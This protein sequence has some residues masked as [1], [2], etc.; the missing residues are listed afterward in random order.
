M[1]GK[2]RFLLKI[3]SESEPYN[4]LHFFSHFINFFI[5]HDFSLLEDIKNTITCP[6]LILHGDID[7]VEVENAKKMHSY[8]Q[9]SS[10]IIIPN[11]GHLPQRKNP[12]LVEK[13]VSEFL[14][15][16]KSS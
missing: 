6:V 9:N 5:N 11:Y 14:F 8:F 15:G 16:S 13:Y 4:K 2:M 10:L 7:Y 12:Q 3:H 1:I